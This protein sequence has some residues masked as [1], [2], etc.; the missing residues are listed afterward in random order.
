MVAKNKDTERKTPIQKLKKIVQIVPRLPP[1]P[2]GVGDYSLRLA[3]KLRDEHSI[4]THFFVFQQGITIEPL[5]NGF[6]TTVLPAHS[7]ETFLSLLPDDIEGIILHYSNYPYLRGKFDAPFWLV[8]ALQL[9]MKQRQ[10]KLVVMFHEL[11]MLK[12]KRINLLNPIQ[13]L[14][15]RRLAK[16]ASTVLTDSAR[17]QAILSQWLKR[18]VTC[19]PDFSTI[20]EPKTVLPLAERNQ[21]VI[22]FGGSDRHRVYKNSLKELLQ[23][24]QILGI[25]EIYDI[26]QPLDLKTQYTFGK[27]H[28]IEMGFQP[29]EVVSQLM[30]TSL[31]GCLDYTRFPGNLGKSSVFAAFCAHGLVPLCTQ[32]NPSE[33]DGI[34]VKKNYLVLDDYLKQLKF[35]ELQTV[36]DNAHQWY[37]SHNL[38]ENAK[39]FA[40]HF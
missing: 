16:I 29:A 8:K 7:P 1:Y 10:I 25:E 28:L 20:G 5:I 30:L 32:Y 24:C 39:V 3:G 6:S 18:T 27:V 15:S 9:S 13:S 2:D 31:A 26:G 14:V 38:T 33:A 12:W 35:E 11:P 4:S 40:S 37:Q 19:I 21:R 17:F 22:V 36:S 34:E 23:Y